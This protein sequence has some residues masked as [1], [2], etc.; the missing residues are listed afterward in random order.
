MTGT[1][2]WRRARLEQAP[3][4]AETVHVVEANE[5]EGRPRGAHVRVVFLR[6]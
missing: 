2:G 6:Y 4:P 3:S 1:L 5:A